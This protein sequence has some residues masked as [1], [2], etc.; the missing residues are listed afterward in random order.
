M[1]RSVRWLVFAG[2]VSAGCSKAQAQG[3][4]PELDPK[5]A[6]TEMWDLE[7]IGKTELLVFAK[8]RVTLGKSCLKGA[9]LDCEAYRVLRAGPKV[10]VKKSSLDGRMSAGSR[11]CLALKGELVTGKSPAGNED[12]FCKLGDGSIVACGPLETYAIKIVP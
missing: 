7:G 5:A 6:T 9:A 1:T 4:A 10:E 3:G 2:I 11:V 12:G 8:E